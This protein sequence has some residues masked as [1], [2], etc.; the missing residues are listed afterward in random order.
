MSAHLDKPLRA[1]Y[2]MRNIPVRKGDEVKI[3]KGKFKGKTGK[4]DVV[5]MQ[6]KR[7][8][9][10]G[11]NNTKKDGTAVK[12]WFHPS[13]LMIKTLNLDDAKRIKSIKKEAV[14]KAAPK[15]TED[16]K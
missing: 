14:E 3:L 7:V 16:K 15:K 12:V 10:E 1:K 8:T 11:I 4:V 6:N 9:V 2:A 13:N 5:E